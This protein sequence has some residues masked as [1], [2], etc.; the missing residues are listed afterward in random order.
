MLQTLNTH[1]TVVLSNAGKTFAKLIFDQEGEILLC[2][3][4]RINILKKADLVWAKPGLQ[5]KTNL[6]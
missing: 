1:K 2:K 5:L 4:K 3:L 6:G